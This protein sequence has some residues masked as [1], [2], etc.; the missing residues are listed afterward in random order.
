[1][2]TTDWAAA[3]YIKIK[4]FS[5][6]KCVAAR[7]PSIQLFIRCIHVAL[8]WMEAALPYLD[9][10][11]AIKSVSS[12]RGIGIVQICRQTSNV[13]RSFW[14]IFLSLKFIYFFCNSP[15]HLVSSNHFIEVKMKVES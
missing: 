3:T 11:L 1:M 8:P 10:V 5:Y 15:H 14:T 2:L 4:N 12:I 7:H 6:L 13:D 9:L